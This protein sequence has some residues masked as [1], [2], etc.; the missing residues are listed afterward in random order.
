MHR[1][2]SLFILSLSVAVPAGAQDLQTAAAAPAAQGARAMAPTPT[3]MAGQRTP[4][5]AVAV[6]APR[7][8]DPG[9]D[10][11]DANIKLA[12]KV[13]DVG[14]GT[15]TTKTVT[16]NVANMSSGRVRSSGGNNHQQ[17]NV[18]ANAELRK[19]GM[20]HVSLTIFY[21]PEEAEEPGAHLDNVNES[22]SVFLKDGVPTVISTAADPTK[23][24]RS[25]SIEVTASVLK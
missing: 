7:H 14:G 2:V 23:G 3:P 13:S 17:L 8:M 21:S 10:Q 9:I 18:D 25:V 5:A 19:S 24:S 4:T 20:V 6:A 15:S 22:I 1:A 11:S 12:V 16:L